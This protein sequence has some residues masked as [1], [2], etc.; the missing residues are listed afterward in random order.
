MGKQTHRVGARPIAA[1]RCVALLAIAGLAGLLFASTSGCLPKPEDAVVECYQRGEEAIRASDAKALRANMS[2]ESY[3]YLKE[4]VSLAQSCPEKEAKALPPSKLGMVV[5][6]RN[7]IDPKRL[8]MMTAE[9]VLAWQMEQGIYFVDADY[10]VYPY[11]TT[12]SGDTAQIQF[13]YEE[14]TRRSGGYRVGRRGGGLV[15]LGVSALASRRKLVPIEGMIAYYRKVNGVWMIDWT[16]NDAADDERLVVEARQANM[17]IPQYVIA[18]EEDETD[19]V[20][21]DIWKPILKIKK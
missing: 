5:M 14:T 3:D 11:K 1:V 18:R 17:T 13:G 16:A 10:G 8:R 15:R 12:I 20:S 21:A 6:M 2:V 9:D 4:C 19:G 7:R